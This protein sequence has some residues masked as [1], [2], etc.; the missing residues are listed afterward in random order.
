[1]LPPSISTG[2]GIPSFGGTRRLFEGNPFPLINK[3]VTP[4]EKKLRIVGAA[5]FALLILARLTYVLWALWRLH[6][7]LPGH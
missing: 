3:S 5:L 4:W 1:M 6:Q 7:T 2:Y